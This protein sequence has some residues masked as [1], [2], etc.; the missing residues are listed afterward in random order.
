MTEALAV[1]TPEVEEHSLTIN[2]PPDAVLAEA[3]RSAQLQG[4][5]A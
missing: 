1:Y 4:V 3:G 2:R 5:L